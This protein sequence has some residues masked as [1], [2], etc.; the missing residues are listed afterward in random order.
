MW[1]F[2]MD[3]DNIHFKIGWCVYTGKVVIEHERH[4]NMGQYYS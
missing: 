3:T 1:V 2:V 4:M